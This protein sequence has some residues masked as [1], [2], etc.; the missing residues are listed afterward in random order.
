MQF[1]REGLLNSALI[2]ERLYSL[3]PGSSLA[4]SDRSASSTESWV[5]DAFIIIFSWPVQVPDAGWKPDLTPLQNQWPEKVNGTQQL[6]D[7][8]ELGKRRCTKF[9][10]F[11]GVLMKAQNLGLGSKEVVFSR[12]KSRVLSQGSCGV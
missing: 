3:R 9:V 8:K 10:T 4:F 1:K 11:Y 5:D 6:T 2:Y 12:Q 7:L